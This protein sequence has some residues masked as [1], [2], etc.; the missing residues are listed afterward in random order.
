MDGVNDLL[1]PYMMLALLAGLGVGGGIALLV[2]AVIGWPR[3]PG[4]GGQSAGQQ[5]A[6]FLRRRVAVAVLVGLVVLVLLKWPVAAI[7]AGLLVMFWSQLFGGLKSEK[8]ALTKVE[9]LAT[10]TESLRD[11]SASA[12]GLEQAIAVSARNA[13]DILKPHLQRL[14]DRVRTRMPLPDALDMLADDI[15]DGGADEVIGALKQSAGLRSTGLREVLTDL[16]R[17]A[18][19]DVGMRRR[20]IASRSQTRRSVQIVVAVIVT[21]VTGLR[22]FNPDYT[23]PYATVQGQLVLVVVFVFFGGSLAW[24]R[25]LSKVPQPARFLVKARVGEAR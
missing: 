23:Q 19:A 1:T 17:K 14:D 24:L 21:I 8:T 11:Q 18:R 22:V 6:G 16:S 12:A 20:I 13:A 15:D 7:A 5:L 2:A 10:W 3:K 4:R 25:R 9:A